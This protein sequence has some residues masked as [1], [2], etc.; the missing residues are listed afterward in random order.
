M[1][2]KC[3]VCGHIFEGDPYSTQSCPQCGSPDISQ[4][5]SSISKQLL[6]RI[7]IGIFALVIIILVVG[8]CGGCSSQQGISCDLITDSDPIIVNVLEG[9]KAASNNKY[10]IRVQ[11][12][13][14]IYVDSAK[15]AGGR[16]SVSKEHLNIPN[17][18]Y[19]FQISR[20]DRSRISPRWIHGNT[21]LCVVEKA[22]CIS[23]TNPIPNMQSKTW[24]INVSV[25][26]GDVSRFILFY[27][28]PQKDTV[29]VTSQEESSF[30]SI[31][32]M[33]RINFFIQAIGN[34]GLK[35]N[36]C[37]PYRLGIPTPPPP[38]MSPAQIDAILSAVARGD[39]KAGTAAAKLRGQVSNSGELENMLTESYA[40]N[41]KCHYNPG[42]K[43]I[44]Q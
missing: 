10:I 4:V 27:V 12:E 2:F 38:P 19:S 34:N 28:N 37:G 24:T 3:N 21:Y 15:V 35:S 13:D 22:P 42:T 32:P 40:D 14:G 9:R 1:K 36:I 6:S 7:L 30:K 5:K 44:S 17:M 8:K 16:A 20:I 26:S 18:V 29:I 31:Q 11:N 39:M 43:R 23:V 25:D 41:H 33:P